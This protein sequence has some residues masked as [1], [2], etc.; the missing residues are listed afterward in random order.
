MTDEYGDTYEAKFEGLY[1]FNEEDGDFKQINFKMETP[2]KI[3]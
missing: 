1:E 2:T 3:S